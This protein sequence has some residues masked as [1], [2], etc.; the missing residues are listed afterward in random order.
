MSAPNDNNSNASAINPTFARR[1]A[2]DDCPMCPDAEGDDTVATLP[3][4]RVHLQNDANYRG[5]CTLVFRRHAIELHD[6]SRDERAQWIEDVARIGAAVSRLC[7]P[8]KLNVVMLG[9]QVPH[10]H[11]HVMPRYPDDPEWGHPPAFRRPRDR[12]LL[13]PE[14]YAQLRDA[15][16]DWLASEPTPDKTR[17]GEN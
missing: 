2:G 17:I 13:P 4:G 5:Y 16:S 14:E 3:S 10:L 15:L 8:A 11:C 6:L 9:N 12:R 1:K 7:Q